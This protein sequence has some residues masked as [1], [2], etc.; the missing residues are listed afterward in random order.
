[1]NIAP[2]P[3]T[4][5]K[6]FYVYE[7]RKATTGDAFYVGKGSLK[8]AWAQSNRSAWWK[9]IA[10]KHGVVVRIIQDGLQE[11]AAHELEVGMIVLHGR[12]DESRGPLINMTD[13]GDGTSGWKPTPETI[14]RISESNKGRKLTPEQR[15]AASAR[16]AGVCRGKYSAAHRLAISASKIGSKASEKTR[17]KI[18]S[19]QRSK[20]R[21]IEC[22]E[23]GITFF[24]TRDASAWLRGNGF[25]KAA[26]T[27][28]SRAAKRSIKA[29]G[30]TWRYAE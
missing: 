5:P 2:P 15:A 9:R 27:S 24:T 8:R 17:A 12:A 25:S 22:V 23:A 7:H 18:S 14:Q 21:P 3:A 20:I 13:G 4:L 29:H 26:R 28:I 1:M 16:Q 6:D 11:W 10:A 30:Y 19:A